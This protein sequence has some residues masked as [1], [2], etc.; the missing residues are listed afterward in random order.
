[1]TGEGMDALWEAVD[2]AREEYEEFYKPDMERR[3][4]ERQD[5]EK[6]KK[7]AQLDAVRRDLAEDDGDTV[8]ATTPAAAIQAQLTPGPSSGAVSQPTK[9]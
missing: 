3:I 7:K 5:A 1:V 8:V 2:Q 9:R 6:A 4:R